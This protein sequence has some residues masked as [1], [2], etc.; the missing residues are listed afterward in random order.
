MARAI[1]TFRLDN[2]AK[3][4]AQKAAADERRTLSQWIENTVIDRLVAEG[5]LPAPKK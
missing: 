1:V 5:R 4:A 3:D 2:A